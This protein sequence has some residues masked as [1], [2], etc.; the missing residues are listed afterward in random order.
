[1]AAADRI[2][3]IITDNLEGAEVQVFD[4]RNDGMHL[5][6][7]VVSSK[8]EGLSLLKQHRL[9]M[10]ALKEHF[11]DASLHALHLKTYTPKQW[12]KKETYAD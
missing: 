5:E 9:V 6:A 12:Q 3:K 7:T 10:N 4:P 11:N 1:M 2:K 8:F